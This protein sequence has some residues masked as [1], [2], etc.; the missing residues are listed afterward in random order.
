[1]RASES[2]ADA[3]AQVDKLESERLGIDNRLNQVVKTL[4][5]QKLLTSQRRELAREVERLRKSVSTLERE[6]REH[7][8][9]ASEAERIPQLEERERELS[10]ACAQLRATI[11]HEQRVR[12]E[13]KDG[14]C[15]ILRERC[16]SFNEGR[17]FDTYFGDQLKANRVRLVATEK[18]LVQVEQAVATAREAERNLAR[19]E[20]SRR[21][22]VEDRTL[23]SERESSLARLD[24]QLARLP[25]ASEKLKDELQAELFGVDASLKVAREAAMR[26]TELET[27][28]ERLT[29]IEEEGK[30]KKEERE[31]LQ[32]AAG[33]L[34][35]LEEDVRDTEASLRALRDPRSR[36]AA[37]RAEAERES[38]LQAEIKNV[39]E[40]LDSHEKQKAALL[41]RLDKF[42]DLDAR[43]I[44][45]SARRERTAEGYREYLESASLASTLGTR[46]TEVEE[47]SKQAAEVEENLS[48][49]RAAHTSIANA[50]E[51]ERHSSERG[52]LAHAR[53]RIAAFNAQLEAAAQRESALRTEIDRLEEVRGAWRDELRAIERLENI[54]E[55]TDFIRDILKQAGP[56]V[57]ESYLYNISIEANQLFREITGDAE[58]SLRWTKEYEI[59]LEEAG[60]ERS[61]VNLSGGEQM[62]AALSVRLALLKQ[63]SDIRVAFFDEPTVNMDAERRERLAQQIG[64]VRHF[65]QLF[66]ISHDDTFEQTVDHV[67]TISRESQQAA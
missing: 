6:A 50:Y 37:F 52:A 5:E 14:V 27:L 63:L 30:T 41:R 7:K 25:E 40:V 57:T 67:V 11:E 9:T 38:S 46:T 32:A 13:T 59:V 58:R 36:A 17:T 28:R 23:F 4:T 55:A 20:A 45:E 26:F 16:T 22:M 54:H 60:H 29:E 34:V 64:Q 53:E 18:E 12:E 24:E 33:A 62:V 44:E 2:A 15:P 43:I 8:Q 61:F 10:R 21:R 42:K 48:K 65:D 51:R 56:L 47:A 35:S 39:S 49:A 1:M 19:L 66:V 31:Q 3:Q